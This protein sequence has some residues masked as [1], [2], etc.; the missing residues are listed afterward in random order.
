MKGGIKPNL[1]SVIAQDF[2][3]VDLDSHSMRIAI[4]FSYGISNPQPG[5]KSLVSDA[6]APQL[7]RAASGLTG[8]A[9]LTAKDLFD[10]RPA[11]RILYISAR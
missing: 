3:F 6:L 10:G 11:R 4:P 9:E 2:H 8:A 1:G 7:L 5:L